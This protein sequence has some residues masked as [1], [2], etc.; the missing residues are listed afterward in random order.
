[1][2]IAVTG[3]IVIGQIQ[4]HLQQQDLEPAIIRNG[5]IQQILHQAL[6]HLIGQQFRV[7]LVIQCSIEFG[8]EVG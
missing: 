6:L 5:S 2:Q 3:L 7:Q 1:M 4:L 8:V